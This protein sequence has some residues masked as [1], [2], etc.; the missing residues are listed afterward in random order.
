LPHA[1]AQRREGDSPPLS[2][3]RERAVAG[4]R[5]GVARGIGLIVR[6]LFRPVAKPR[7][8]FV[9][10]RLCVRSASSRLL[11]NA[12]HPEKPSQLCRCF[13]R[14]SGAR[15]VCFLVVNLTQRRK[16]AKGTRLRCRSGEKGP[17]PEGAWAWFEASA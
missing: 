10:L 1:K 7:L 14:P 3:R 17:R 13:C 2:L 12:V 5:P 11:K 9:L 15:I 6:S 8:L 4:R 16:D